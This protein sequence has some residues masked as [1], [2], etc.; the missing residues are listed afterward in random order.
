MPAKEIIEYVQEESRK[1]K[2]AITAERREALRKQGITMIEPENLTP[3]QKR[4]KLLRE[5]EKPGTMDNGTAT[6]FWIIAMIV[7]LLFKG[8]WALCILETIIW[9]KHITR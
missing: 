5:T 3:E 7:S 2:E 1:R 8:G 9:W 4:E 6:V